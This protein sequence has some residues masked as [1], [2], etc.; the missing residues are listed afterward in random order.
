VQINIL[1]AAIV[2]Y[3]D[4]K[5]QLWHTIIKANDTERKLPSTTE[6]SATIWEKKPR[7]FHQIN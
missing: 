3:G 1:L 5:Q 4:A 7:Q 2:F 6:I